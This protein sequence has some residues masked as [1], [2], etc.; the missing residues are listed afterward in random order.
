MVEEKL[1][2]RGAGRVQ[3]V[4]RNHAHDV[5][6]LPLL[7]GER[8]ES[9]S[10]NYDHAGEPRPGFARD[11]GMYDAHLDRLRGDPGAFDGP[12]ICHPAVEQRNRSGDGWP[13]HGRRIP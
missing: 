3:T 12:W 7:S 11:T 8:D 13:D 6:E 4:S 5:R 2:L 10:A 1:R 9:V